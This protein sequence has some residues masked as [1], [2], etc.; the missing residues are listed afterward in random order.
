[1]VLAFLIWTTH[2]VAGQ[3]PAPLL[4]PCMEVSPTDAPGL[5]GT[6]SSWSCITTTGNDQ[7]PAVFPGSQPLELVAGERI[8]FEPGT[9]LDP[10]AQGNIVAR[11]ERS[12]IE[13]VW[14][15]PQAIAGYVGQFEKLEL[16][17]KLPE[18]IEDQIEAFLTTGNGINPF[19]P[20]QISFEAIL[21]KPYGIVDT[22]YGF[23][24]QPYQR[25][26]NINRWVEDTTSYN[27]RLR[28]APEL[29][30]DWQ[31]KVRV[32]TPN[33][34][35]E[36]GMTIEFNCY[37]SGKKGPLELV[38]HPDG[39]IHRYLRYAKNKESF[40]AIGHNICHAGYDTIF[41]VEAAQ[42]QQWITELG[43]NGGNFTRLELGGNNYLPE[44]QNAYRYDQQ[45]PELWE[46]DHTFSLMEQL[47]IYTIVFRHH[48]EMRR[49]HPH[50]N[51]VNWYHNPYRVA[52]DLDTSDYASFFTDPT[53]IQLQKNALR[54][55]F[56]RYGYSPSLTGYSYSEVEYWLQG[57]ILSNNIDP[58][59]AYY[60]FGD[61][62]GNLKDYVQQDLGYYR[63]LWTATFSAIPNDNSLEVGVNNILSECDLLGFHKYSN[64][65]NDFWNYF[66]PEH[67]E[68]Y[69]EF[70][71][72]TFAEECGY[73][74]ILSQYCCTDVDFHKTIWATALMGGMGTGMHWWWDRGIHHGQMYEHYNNI[75]Q[76]VSGVNFIAEDFKP[77]RWRNIPGSNTMTIETY[78]LRSEDKEFGMGWVNNAT[79]YWRNIESSNPC[80][81]ELIQ[82]DSLSSPCV[83]YDGDLLGGP[84]DDEDSGYFAKDEFED[85]YTPTVQAFP[86]GPPS[87]FKILDLKINP[88]QLTSIPDF[89]IPKHWYR[90]TMYNTWDPGLPIIG[91]FVEHTTFNVLALPPRSELVVPLPILLSV[92]RPDIAY[93]VEYL[94]ESL[95]DP[96]KSTDTNGASLELRTSNADS[97]NLWPNP[98]NSQ[99]HIQSVD[100]GIL[101]IRIMDMRGKV[102]HHARFDGIN[103][104]SLDL[105]SEPRGTYLVEVLT[106]RNRSYH[107]L[108]LTR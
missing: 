22:T 57:V 9:V 14:F 86:V 29:M 52:L 91:E 72:P 17:F 94:G 32:V 38:S 1:M 11:I 23:Y 102:V 89:L 93:K 4:I 103:L 35:I 96:T 70:S 53:S 36:P 54:Y 26:L 55:F 79:V 39:G 19:D 100:K 63:T 66:Y 28:V 82:N 73:E 49:K 3:D 58:N 95:T 24:Y 33:E 25:D 108:I 98:S 88:V 16:G 74:K 71:K 78:Q 43:M 31:V 13:A 65:R 105:S 47:D 76:F 7:N 5:N 77:S 97:V 85:T 99:V 67:K 30:G 59:T 34:V 83:M 87:N 2:H 42:H 8:T 50:W 61:W 92:D 20:D 46:L 51:D 101:A 81:A 27:W 80:I 56:A 75:E 41:P 90:V 104:V 84:L 21:Y 107:Q 69:T 6:V 37:A 106:E 64:T 10:S 15:H 45:L 68:L 40:F 12:P 18:S 60:G 48:T 62:F 44:W